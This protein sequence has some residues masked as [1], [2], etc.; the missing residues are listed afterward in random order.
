MHIKI[1]YFL[2]LI[3][4]VVLS[5]TLSG[6]FDL[7]E[8]TED[9]DDYCEA[10][11][12]VGV[13]DGSADVTYYTMEDFYNKNAVNKF[14]SPMDEDERD[15]YSYLFIKVDR[16]LSL[17]EIAVHF[18]STRQE[19]LTVSYFILNDDEVPPKVYTGEGGRYSKDESDEPNVS[20]AIGHAT[21]NLNG[22]ANKWSVAYLKSW[23]D[24]EV[25]T[26]R[27]DIQAGQYLVL[28]LDNNCYDPALIL[29]EAAQKEYQRI[30]EEY[31]AKYDAYQAVLNNP[32]ATQEER[33]VAMNALSEA[34]ADKNVGEK[35]FEEAQATYEKTKFPY[36]KVEVRITA[37]LINSK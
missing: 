1:R 25:T 35:D 33:N 19:T 3:C 31:Q 6:C 18:E 28:R 15:Y 26:K 12:E 10:Y 20:R 23:T 13:I 29:Y 17:G 16:D 37:I 5:F 14:E 2:L 8:G 34:T 21:C 11:P 27:H 36:E 24:G 22:V 30:L 9:D 7:G 32:S 4:I